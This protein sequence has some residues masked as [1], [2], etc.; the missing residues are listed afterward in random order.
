MKTQ[1]ER[2]NDLINQEMKATLD[3]PETAKRC[4][5]AGVRWKEEQDRW[6]PVTEDLP[7]ERVPVLVR[8]SE[9][10]YDV[11]FIF[12]GKWMTRAGKITHWKPFSKVVG[13]NKNNES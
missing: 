2:I 3:V 11:G 8:G 7:E 4:F 9:D 10:S 5:I 12:N 6:I 13:D 1:E